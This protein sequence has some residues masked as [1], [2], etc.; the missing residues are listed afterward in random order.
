M[1]V[2]RLGNRWDGVKRG[3]LYRGLTIVILG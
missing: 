3:I 1:A 2:R